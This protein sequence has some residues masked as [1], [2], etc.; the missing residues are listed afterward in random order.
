VTT[1]RRSKDTWTLFKIMAEFV[2]GF[3]KLR[4]VWPAV[5]I[6]GSARLPEGHRYYRDAMRV[7][8]ALSDAGFSVITG[9]G[10]GV[11]EAANRGA[12]DGASRSIGLN[13]KLPHEQMPNEYADEVIHF[14]YFF[15]RKV[16]FVKYTCALV[17]MPGGF[18]TLDEVFEAL[19]LSQ[20]HKVNQFPVVLFGSDYW[21]G[22]FE[23]I[24]KHALHEGMI[25]EADLELVRITDSV[26]E[27]VELVQ[28]AYGERQRERGPEADEGRDTP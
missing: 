13:I 26:D 10:P 20:T 19:T 17:G 14:Q 24:R 8:E 11:M 6:W 12:A 15:A 2:E 1:D 23:W 5:A 22:L 16:M 7:S 28:R 4:P 21:E 3:E 27:V 18:G 9:G 25:S